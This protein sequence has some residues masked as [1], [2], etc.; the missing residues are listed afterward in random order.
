MDWSLKRII[1]KTRL[2][3]RTENACDLYYGNH[4]KWVYHK[5][6]V[7]IR[8]AIKK[9]GLIPYD[10]LEFLGENAEEKQQYLG[11]LLRT[12]NQ[13]HGFAFS[14]LISTLAAIDTM[15]TLYSEY[16]G[17]PNDTL[18]V[19]GYPLTIEVYTRD[20]PDRPAGMFTYTDVKTFFD[21]LLNDTIIPSRVSRVFAV[22]GDANYNLRFNAKPSNYDSVFS[23]EAYELKQFKRLQRIM[24][25]PINLN[26]FFWCALKGSK[27]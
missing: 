22:Y 5:R 1:Q 11:L 15:H 23:E 21:S 9:L 18:V 20:S 27:L 13:L 6:A 2:L 7:S 25:N 26:L 12:L 3:T 14:Q 10:R 16:G 8:H 4:V 24:S 19:S 17:N